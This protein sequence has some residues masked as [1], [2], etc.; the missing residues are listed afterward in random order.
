MVSACLE[1]K[2]TRDIAHDSTSR[3]FSFQEFIQRYA[4]SKLTQGDM[5]SI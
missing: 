2:T 4:D 1:I 3:S 5:F